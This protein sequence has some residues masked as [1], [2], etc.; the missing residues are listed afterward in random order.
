MKFSDGN[1][2]TQP[3]YKIHTPKLVYDVQRGDNS[4]TFYA[5]CKYI[6]HR[7]D[8]LDGPLLTVKVSSPLN[9]V[10]RVQAW[11]FKGQKERGPWFDL[12]EN[13]SEAIIE[14]NESFALLQ[15]GSLKAR[16]HK[17]TWSVDFLNGNKNLTNS[18]PN[19]LAY[20][21]SEDGSTYMREQLNLGV[22][23]NIYGLGERFTPF[24][25]NGQ[26][27]DIWNKDGGTSTE[28]AY[29]NIPF[30][31]SNNGYGVFVNHP[32]LV[33]FEVGSEIVSKSQFSV[34]GEKL[35]YYI[36]NGPTPKDVLKHYT[37]L[38]GKPALPPAWSFG[39]WLTT[40]FTTDYDEGTVNHFIDEMHKRDLPLSVFHFDCFWMK[41]YEW[42]NFKWNR[43]TFPEPEKMLKRLKDRGLKISV[44]INPYIAQKSELF[45]EGMNNGYLLK[46][47]NGD[48]WQWDLW[49]AGQG[50]VDFTNP[51]ARAWYR[52]KLEALIDMGVDSFKTDFG[53][54][55]PTDVVYYDG[56]DPY[57]MHNYYTQMYNWLVFDLLRGKLGT[58]QAV[59]FARSATAG[60]QQFPVH[61]GGDCSASFES[62]G[63]S[64]RGGL[65]LT[66]SGFGYWSH[67]IGGF[68]N[69]AA[70][71]LFKRWTAFGLLSSHS[72]LHGSSSYRVPWLFDE[73]A[74][75]VTRFFIKLKHRLMPYIFTSACMTSETGIPLMR[76]MMMEFPEDPSCTFIDT[77]YMLGDSILAGP[78]FNEDGIAST[79]LP[80]GTWTNLIT[81]EEIYGGSWIKDAYDYFHLPLF[82]RENTLLHVGDNEQKPDYDYAEDVTFHLFALGNNQETETDVYNVHGERILHAEAVRTGN[83]ITISNE[84]LTDS[85]PWHVLLRNIYSVS[86]VRNAHFHEV[87]KGILLTPEPLDKSI[88]LKI[89]AD[90]A[91]V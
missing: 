40:S 12:S 17:D 85:K 77:Q 23:E 9:N 63:E 32:E 57:K 18:S 15:S 14:D 27:V 29:K 20:I 21:T 8:T 79:Y 88:T 10:I 30:Y 59:L 72:R 42:C 65:S 74:V 70:P 46:R 48:V 4:I 43:S 11:H 37:D 41:E 82:V 45:E 36:I 38:T 81:N 86:E 68:E 5:P 58:H 87:E 73:E 53:E 26:T 35:D 2:L 91:H 80:K 44:W 47:P 84:M 1:W 67:D 39:L 22:G 31:L 56:S 64:L 90:P 61:W 83:S 3:G 50:I 24:V 16:I 76:P 13:A 71:D 28:Q 49:Q 89:P 75:D 34:E 52:E 33:S 66:S 19:S 69:T 78:V 54:R 25:K 7:G 6:N 55:I 62:M 60:G 51:D